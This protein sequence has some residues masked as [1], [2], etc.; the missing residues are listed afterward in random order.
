[1]KYLF[2]LCL[3][4]LLLPSISFGDITSDSA[5]GSIAGSASQS[6]SIGYIDNGTRTSE[7]ADFGERAP[8]V[9]AAGVTAGGSN[10]CVVS[11]GG[12]LS[13]PGGGLNFANAY[14]DTECQIRE[15]LRLFAA[16]THPAEGTNQIL[17]REIACQSVVYWDA[18]YRVYSETHDDTYYCSNE[19]PETEERLSFR[20]DNLNGEPTVLVKQK[21]E[22]TASN[23][24]F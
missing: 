16:I 5:S 9:F 10:P 12:G 18:F 22:V 20:R 11:I 17:L 1:M 8:G 15:S 2:I 13:V 3:S 19:R 4:C 21:K 6:G 14:N 23:G 7:A 24:F